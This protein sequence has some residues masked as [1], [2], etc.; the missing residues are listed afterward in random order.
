M[1]KVLINPAGAFTAQIP[2][3]LKNSERLFLL[4]SGL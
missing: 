2:P 4:A 3:K 1:N